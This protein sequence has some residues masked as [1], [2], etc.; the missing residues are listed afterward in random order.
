MKLLWTDVRVVP[1]DEELVENTTRAIGIHTEK[2]KPLTEV[3][4][5]N[6][7]KPDQS[8]SSLKTNIIPAVPSAVGRRKIQTH[9]SDP[10]QSHIPV[11]PKEDK[12]S[13]ALVDSKAVECPTSDTITK[14]APP[15]KPSNTGGSSRRNRKGKKA[16]KTSIAAAKQ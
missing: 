8:S 1:E 15:S 2:I 7:A 14:A 5:D 11:S 4:E 16:P 13:H 9:P 12:N 10:E 6:T 3:T